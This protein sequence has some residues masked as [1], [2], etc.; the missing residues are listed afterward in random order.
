MQNIKPCCNIECKN[1]HSCF[2]YVA[3][4]GSFANQFQKYPGNEACEKQGFFMKL[5]PMDIKFQTIRDAKTADLQACKTYA[6]VYLPEASKTE[7]PNIAAEN[8][9][10]AEEAA[11]AKA[12]LDA[13][14]AARVV[15][16]T[17][18]AADPE[19]IE[20]GTTNETETN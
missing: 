3:L 4:S 16:T 7:A 12:E 15:D 10:L 19:T 6:K 17:P 11:A 8:A 14:E 20:Q 9:R 5:N 1:R 13:I 18:P 2:R